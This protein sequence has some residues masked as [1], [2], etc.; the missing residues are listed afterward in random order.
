MAEAS[1]GVSEKISEKPACILCLGMAGSGKTTFVQVLLFS[2]QYVVHRLI[3]TANFIKEN[4]ARALGMRGGSLEIWQRRSAE[5]C[6]P[7]PTAIS[8]P[9]RVPR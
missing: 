1:A 5:I 7:P 9:K 4:R 3:L 8:D 2:C 6:N